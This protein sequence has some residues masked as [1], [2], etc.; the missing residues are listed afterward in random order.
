MWND[1]PCVWE[2]VHNRCLKFS[3]PMILRAGTNLDDL[4]FFLIFVPI[5]A[6]DDFRCQ[7]CSML[8]SFNEGIILYV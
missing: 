1:W 3:M 4:I 5:W 8:L 2:D 7:K 6:G